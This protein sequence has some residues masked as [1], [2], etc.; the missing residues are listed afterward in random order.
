MLCN[1]T[2]RQNDLQ[3]ETLPDS[4]VIEKCFQQ[5]PVDRPWEGFPSKCGYPLKL[6]V[7]PSAG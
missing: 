6:E 3:G 7:V 1:Q 2:G 4:A 5:T